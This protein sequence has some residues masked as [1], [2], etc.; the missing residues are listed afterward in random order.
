MQ[1]VAMAQ[2]SRF[3]LAAVL[4]A[5]LSQSTT[6]PPIYLD[7]CYNL[8]VDGAPHD[9]MPGCDV[10]GKTGWLSLL[11]HLALGKYNSPA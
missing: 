4:A 7:G 9:L 3:P 11:Q 2:Q 6:S 8:K 5:G 10:Q 1:V